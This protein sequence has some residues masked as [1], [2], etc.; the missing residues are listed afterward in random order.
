MELIPVACVYE[1]VGRKIRHVGIYNSPGAGADPD[2][3]FVVLPNKTDGFPHYTALEDLEELLIQEG[4]TDLLRMVREKMAEAR[5]G[6]S[7][8]RRRK[9]TSTEMLKQLARRLG[10]TEPI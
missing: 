6:L 9:M 3:Q 4:R 10:I 8:P 7:I 1:I 5:L 2:N